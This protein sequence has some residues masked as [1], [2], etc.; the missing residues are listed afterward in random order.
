MKIVKELKKIL[1]ESVKA[2]EI[3]IKEEE[4]KI[5]HPGDVNFGDYSTNVAMVLGKVNKINPKELAESIRS[6]I[7]DIGSQ[8]VEKVEVAGAGFINFYL[9]PE[10][11]IKEAESINYEIEFKNK[12][13]KNGNGKTMVIDYSAPNIAKPFGIGHLRSTDIGQAIYNIYKILGWNCIGDNHIGDWGT[14]YGKLVAAIKKWNKKELNDLTIDDL[15]KLYVKFHK[16]AESDEKLIDEG[17]DWFAKLEKGNKE[18]KEIWQKCIDI[19]LVE[20]DRVYEMLGVKIDFIHGESFYQDKLEEVTKKIISKGI[21]KKSEGAVIV[22]FKNMPPAMLQKSNGTTTYFTR[23]MATI[24]YRLENW[25]PDLIIYEVG[26]DQELHFRQVFETAKMMGWTPSEGLVH[27]AHGLIRWTTGKFSTRKGD[28]IHLSDVIDKAMEKA[29]E[30]ANKSVVDKK[31]S[32]TEKEEMIKSV[33]IGA[34]KFNDLSSDPRRDVI[35]DWEK[36]M[37]LDGDSGP[38]LQY[39]YARGISVLNK[40]QLKEQKNINKIPKEINAEEMALIKEFYKFE[41][42]IME[43]SE[44]YSPAVIAE[45]LLSVARKY[46]E[47]YAKNRIID[48]KQENFRIFLT[49]TTTS[50]LHTGLHLLGIKTI[51]K[52]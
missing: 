47:F 14:Q 41:E 26:N 45:Y 2:L 31:L 22:E 20:F 38:Y 11:L 52:M 36:I 17:R 18:A 37:S 49:K 32:A 33:A 27:I 44:R 15:E 40:T 9:K 7:S 3:N 16:E 13:S 23:D 6:Q 5:E 50:I 4:I 8:I 43:A 12:L 21:T 25:N 24:K 48:E 19:S 28:T 42:K 1:I 46:N 30:I 51:E 10:F 29:E 35:F 34:I 39:T